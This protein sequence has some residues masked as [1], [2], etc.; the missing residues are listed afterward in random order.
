MLPTLRAD[1]E[2]TETYTYT[3]REPLDCAISAFGGSEDDSVTSDELAAWHHQTTGPFRFHLFSGGHFFINSH[4]VPL[5][6]L[7]SREIEQIIE[8][9]QR[10]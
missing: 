8:H 7:I 5:L 9:S 1:F 6:K 4:Q 2:A 3:D 10:R